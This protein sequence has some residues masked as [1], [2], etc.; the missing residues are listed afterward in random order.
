MRHRAWTAGIAGGIAAA[1]TLAGGG[2]VWAAPPPDLSGLW[3]NGSLT[4]LERPKDLKGLVLSEAE[5]AAY[6][7]KWRG[8]SPEIE[9][10]VGGADSEWWELDHGLGRVRGQARSSW[11]VS[12]ADG[13]LP[14]TT[15]AK[16]VNAERMTGRKGPTNNPEERGRGDRCLP[17][18]AA[19]PPMLNGVYN[20]HFAFLQ[21]PGAL[22]IHA[23]YFNDVRIVRLEPGATHPPPGVRR[24]LGDSIGRW[25]GG[26][27]VIETTNFTAL[28]VDAPDR[29][30]AAD[31]TVTERLTRLGPGQLHYAF[32]VRNPAR[33][34]MPWQ[35][36]MV[37]Q[38]AAGPMFEFACHEGNYS[39]TSMLSAARQ[40]EAAVT[41]AP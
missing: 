8:K 34:V 30:P 9:D 41:A 25:E 21:T 22:V 36:E 37:L 18:A 1:L 26:T 2:A 14:Y 38:A 33:Y 4:K 24:W 31:M 20:N 40:A 35:G 3:T 32:T 16:A 10:D 19:G 15:A 11:I 29:D 17:G 6:E 12:P 7:A 27:L 39:L 5:A 13:K 23:E 28:E